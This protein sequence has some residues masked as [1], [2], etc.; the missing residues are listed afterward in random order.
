[1]MSENNNSYSD[2]LSVGLIQSTLDKDIA[3]SDK[4]SCNIDELEGDRVW[5]EVVNGM[6]SLYKGEHQ[7]DIILMPELTISR[8]YISKLGKLCV[9]TNSVI[10]A[11]L[12]YNVNESEK[13]VVNE[14]VVVYPE[15]WPKNFGYG[16]KKIIL[17]KYHYARVEEILLNKRGYKVK[18]NPYIYVF[19]SGDFGRIGVAIC[20]DFFDIERF[21]IYKGK[22]QHLFIIAYNKDI[23]SFYFLAEAIS[24]LV[25][26]NVVICN[27]GFYGGS[28][29]FTPYNQH[30][31][32]YLYKHEGVSLFTSQTVKI[33]VKN[34]VIAQQ[35]DD[36][37]YKLGDDRFK[38]KP[39]GYSITI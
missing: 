7:P 12:D 39:P 8:K 30:F 14:V 4:N 11:G 16:F 27:T 19:D 33:P 32:R 36:D 24:R 5:V 1:M 29:V 21:V 18:Q 3:W 28:I 25:F 31:K 35:S 22:I 2:F 6:K 9:S 20:A 26:C 34:L 38:Y 15:R 17:G 10:I 23:S 37:N 13:T